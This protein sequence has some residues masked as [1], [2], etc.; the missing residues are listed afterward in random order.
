MSI[1]F[2]ILGNQ[3]ISVYVFLYHANVYVIKFR[4][5]YGLLVIKVN[6]IW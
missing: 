1:L 3:S 4:I 2:D 6:Q 5:S